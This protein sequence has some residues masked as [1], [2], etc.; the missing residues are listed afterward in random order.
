[1]KDALKLFHED[2]ESIFEVAKEK[3]NYEQFAVTCKKTFDLP[4]N[5]CL[6]SAK[7]AIEPYIDQ[8]E[9][10]VHLLSI[11]QENVEKMIFKFK[12][13]DESFKNGIYSMSPG[14]N[15]DSQLAFNFNEI[16]WIEV[17]KFE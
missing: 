11:I 1:M 4:I 3:F 9:V 14:F 16:N 17:N 15:R 7:L 12:L 6:E 13:T 8:T 2:I 10:A 5:L